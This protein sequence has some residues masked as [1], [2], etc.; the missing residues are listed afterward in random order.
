MSECEKKFYQLLSIL[1]T[2]SDNY[3]ITLQRR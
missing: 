1:I 3:E 2:S